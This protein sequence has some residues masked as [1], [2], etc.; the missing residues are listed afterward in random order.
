MT[1]VA[2]GACLAAGQSMASGASSLGARAGV[3]VAPGEVAA[4]FGSVTGASRN[5]SLA[6]ELLPATKGS[7]GTE[8]RQLTKSERLAGQRIRPKYIVP[9][10]GVFTSGF[11]SRWGSTHYG[12]DIANSKGTPIV[13]VT[14]GTVIEAG[15]ASGFGLW[16]RVLHDDGTITVYGH[17]NTITAQHGQ[18]VRAGDQIATMGNRGLSNGVHLHFEVWD[19]SGKKIDPLPWLAVRGITIPGAS[20]AD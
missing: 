12:I 11:G 4:A 10:V 13:S 17:V 2:A 5:S 7:L 20:A 8:V 15:P 9:A 1:A 18:R 16:V 6:P 19:P 14:D 3:G